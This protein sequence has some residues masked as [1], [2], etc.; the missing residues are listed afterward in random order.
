MNFDTG[1]ISGIPAAG[2]EGN[3][4]IGIQVCASGQ[5]DQEMITLTVS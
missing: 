5:C 4:E 3:Y 2:T 1:F